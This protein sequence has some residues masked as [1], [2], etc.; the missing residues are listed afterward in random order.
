MDL[1]TEKHCRT[2]FRAKPLKREVMI[3]RYEKIIKRQEQRRLESN[4]L[5]L[6]WQNNKKNLLVLQRPS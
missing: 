2:Y 4:K 5:V 3:P 1:D 6:L